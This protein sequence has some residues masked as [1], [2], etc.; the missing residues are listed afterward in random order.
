[1][2]PGD[3]R[4]PVTILTGWLGAGK[5]TL[6]NRILREPRGLRWAVLV[7]EF[8][9]VGIDHRLVVRSDEQTVE[10]SNG[11]VC[12][13]VR[14]DL[15]EALARLRRRRPPWFRRR[16]FDRV[17]IETT[18]LAE[19][20]P[21]LRTF[22][23]EAGVSA[24]YVV[25]SIVTVVDAANAHAALMEHAAQEQ[26]ALADL[27]VLNKS[28]LVDAPAL[29]ALRDRLAALN[30]AAAIAESVRGD[31]PLEDLLAAGA[32]RA[33][34]ALPP[35]HDHGEDAHDGIGSLS[36]RCDAP[37]DELK[38]KLWLDGAVR[39][40]GPRLIRFKGFLHL[41]DRPYRGVLQGVY[42]LYTV[43]AGLPWVEG[44]P[45]SSEIVFIGRGLDRGFLQRGLTAAAAN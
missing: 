11:C 3:P 21:L 6:L 9:E 14:G 2:L 34:D 22:L 44:E 35:T 25:T 15:V 23:V 4:T 18:G 20:A 7:N 32:P 13:T 37:L 43:E 17:L 28:D 16:R 39:L 10:L 12:C 31:L 26:T 24:A 33:L 38:A 8:G 42:E 41:A 1:M 36:L 27:I 30:P 40:L 45:R 5:T 29:K 19:P